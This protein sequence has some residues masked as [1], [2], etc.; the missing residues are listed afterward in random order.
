[1]LF[2]KNLTISPEK[3]HQLMQSGELY[4]LLDVR[5][6]EEFAEGHIEGAKLLPVD[7]I[8]EKASSVLPDKN[9]LILIYCRSGMRAGTAA[10]QLDKM[11][12]TNVFSFGGIMNWPYDVQRGR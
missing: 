8:A 12:Y 9:A 1:M 6:P 5:Q 4:V 3:A 11:G 10:K 2:G 7:E